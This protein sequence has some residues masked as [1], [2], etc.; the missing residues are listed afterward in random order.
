MNG[1]NGKVY[2]EEN[3][4]ILGKWFALERKQKGYSIRGLSRAANITASLISDIENQKVKPNLDTLKQ[5][6]Q[7][8]DIT[9][10]T[11]TERLKAVQENILSLYYAIY[12]HNVETIKTL[13]AGIKSQA[14]TLRYSPITVDIIILEAFMPS[15]LK[16]HTV[17][18]AFYAL[19]NH[20]SFLSTT[21][22]ER[23]YL[24]LGYHQFHAKDDLNAL[25]S[26]QKAISYHREGRGSTVA[27][28]MMAKIHSRALKPLDAIELGSKA[29][30]AHAKWSNLIR[31]IDCDFILIKSYLETGQYN[32]AEALIQNLSYVLVESNQRQWFE[33]KA[34]EAYL[35]YKR[36]HFE[37][38]I[39]KILMIP[40]RNCYLDLVLLN[41]YVRQDVQ[42]EAEALYE[43]LS[44]TCTE[45]KDTL[46]HAILTLIYHQNTKVQLR[47]MDQ[48]I[49][50]II[51]RLK[52]IDEF[53]LVKEVI[54]MAAHYA[55]INKDLDQLAKWFEISR[56]IM[57]FENFYV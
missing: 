18:S 19:E 14:Q 26:F 32:R 6:Y 31:K 15:I 23:F 4:F 37:R 16:G 7:Q 20:F 27:Y 17:P 34:F 36:G 57:N 3:L 9:F 47:I 1:E 51:P 38:A 45:K 52:T 50:T 46:M 42:V 10:I 48:A 29:S 13:Y 11:E 44:K 5:L 43:R 22:Q 24:A 49:H 33:L 12:D 21:Q 53:D 25:A 30:K 55:T 56:K 35:D 39:Q 2:V 8:L 54:Q 40:E 41:I 28:E